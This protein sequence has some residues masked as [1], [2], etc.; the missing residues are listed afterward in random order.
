MKKKT[1]RKYP[2]KA[3]KPEYEPDKNGT[4]Q[5]IMDAYLEYVNYYEEYVNYPSHRLISEILKKFRFIRT[6]TKLRIP[7]L[8]EHHALVRKDRNRFLQEKRENKR[9]KQENQ[10]NTGK[11]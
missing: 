9:K 7:E 8:R 5:A 10:N 4:H 11:K 6:Q 1:K 2:S 3:Y